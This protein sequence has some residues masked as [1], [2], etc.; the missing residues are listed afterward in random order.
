MNEK[1]NYF[2]TN[3]SMPGHFRYSI[4]VFGLNKEFSKFEDLPFH[5]EHLTNNMKL[6]DYSY[7]QGG[8]YTAIAFVG[9]PADGRPGCKSVFWVKSTKSKD[10][11]IEII[12]SNSVAMEIIS[13]ISS[14]LA[15]KILKKDE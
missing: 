9:S 4:D 7:Y 5:P 15:G 12:R 11:M 3:L 10:E 1:L 14:D 13:K 8:G 2:G 6:G